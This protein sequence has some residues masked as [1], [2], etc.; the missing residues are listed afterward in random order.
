[1][2][3][4]VVTISSGDNW[5]VVLEN[6]DD[7]GY[8]WTSERATRSETTTPGFKPKKI[9]AHEMYA[10]P[11]ITQKSLDDLAFNVEGWLSGS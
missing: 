2:I 7:A 11:G 4:N 9:Y 8:G 1:M 6:S 10:M 3:A 5:E